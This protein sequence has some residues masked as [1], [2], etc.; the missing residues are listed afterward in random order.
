MDAYRLT[1]IQLSESNRWHVHYQL[2]TVQLH[3]TI[4]NRRH[5]VSE[6]RD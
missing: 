4:K 5:M 2:C 1:I 6:I 3:V